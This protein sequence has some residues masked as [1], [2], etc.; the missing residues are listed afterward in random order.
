MIWRDWMDAVLLERYA[1]EGNA[2]LAGELGVSKRT[3]ER[4]ASMLGLRKSAEFL[5]DV[6]RGALDVVAWMRA[7]GRRC[8]G[9][10][11]GEGKATSGS[12]RKGHR[13]DGEVEAKRVK[14][15]R[16]RAWDERVRA[17]RGMRRNTGWRMTDYGK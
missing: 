15:I 11:K 7:C 1:S 6:R 3:L 10:R 12:F 4:H 8:G 5:E 14:A 2:S 13:F 17:I 9:V 16:D